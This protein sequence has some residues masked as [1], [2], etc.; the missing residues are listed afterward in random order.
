MDW[1]IENWATVMELCGAIIVVASIIVKITPTK[2]D[3][4][5]LAKFLK[6]WEFLA[7]NNKPVEKK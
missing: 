1:I 4:E 6:F 7:L 5:V 2:V 3:N